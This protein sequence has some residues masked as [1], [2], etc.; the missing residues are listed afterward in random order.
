MA[1]QSF[2]AR[3]ARYARDVI[4]GRVPA[5]QW[6]VAACVRHL[7]DLDCAKRDKSW[8]YRYDKS[9]AE[10]VCE[11]IEL[12]PH[13]K[14]AKARNGELI[15]LEPWQAFILCSAFGWVHRETGHRR[16]R[17]VYIEVPRGNA[18]STLSSGVALYMLLADGEA[19]PEVYSAATKRD[20][21]KIVFG[22]AQ[23]MARKRPDMVRYYGMDVQKHGILV[24]GNS[25]QFSALSRDGE[26]QD[27]LN[28]HFACLDELHAHKNREIY[29]VVETGAGKRDQSMIWSITTAGSNRSGI[30]YETRTF[31]TAVLRSTLKAWGKSPYPVKGDT[32]DDEQFFGLIYTLDDDDDWTD[33]K[34]WR[35]ANP[36]WGVSVMPD[37]VAGLAHKAMQVASAQNA[38]K[39]KHLDLW[40]N[41]D[42]A[43]MDM[44]A[45]DRCADRSLS[46]DDFTDEECVIALD[47][48]S[49][50]DLAAKMKLF[51]RDIDG[52]T[53]YYAFGTYY[54]PRR[55]IEESGNSQY[56]GWEIEGRLQITEGDVIDFE[57]I[58]ADLTIDA[59]QHGVK[60]VA[61]DPWQATQM[62][63]R[64]AAQG[65]PML[66][67]RNTVANFSEPMKELEALVL[68]GRFHHDGDPVLTWA[69]SNVVCHTD[70]KDNIY[71][72]KE[73]VEN[74]IDP[75]V[76]LIMAL[77]RAMTRT[78]TAFVYEGM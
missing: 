1:K 75:A 11:F 20:Q 51:E 8:Q 30:C 53:H 4:A 34:V 13:I 49:K 76:A 77:G 73:R 54:L 42:Q 39:T 56:A 67:Y 43:W 31:L 66:E 35:K 25:G 38:F 2:T 32:A 58:E 63:Q 48:A 64:M 33:E 12:M 16:F 72:R 78:E 21:A 27:G 24:P 45:W 41:A 10:L 59:G 71:P 46:V 61:Y 47:L 9:K 26:T 44:L 70:A 69:I 15:R 62:A 74:K 68:Q 23:A 17:R 14:G 3:A 19:G 65:L 22:D 5:C 60:D 6:V 18:K 50:I 55:Q 28:I 37:Y 40:V 36:N 52:S 7:M 57:N 29:D